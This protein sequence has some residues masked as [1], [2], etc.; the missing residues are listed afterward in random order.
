LALVYFHLPLSLEARPEDLPFL[1]LT[2][3]VS[4]ELY[5]SP[6]FLGSFLMFGLGFGLIAY[7]GWRTATGP[8]WLNGVGIVA[9]LS[10]LVWLAPFLPPFLGPLTGF[11][12]PLN[13]LTVMV[14]SIG[15]SIVLVRQRDL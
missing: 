13:I 15:L 2:T 6:W 14:W 10:G 4:L 5:E 12:I 9:G 1:K 7:Y 3:E 11:L 8:K